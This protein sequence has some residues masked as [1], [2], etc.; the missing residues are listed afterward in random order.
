MAS[1]IIILNWLFNP[2]RKSA[3]GGES[4]MGDLVEEDSK[5]DD[6]KD[7]SKYDMRGAEPTRRLSAVNGLKTLSRR[8]S[9]NGHTSLFG[10][11]K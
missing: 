2:Q 10:F 8:L 5:Y 11:N 3:K 4:K 7:E 6:G 9:S 1:S